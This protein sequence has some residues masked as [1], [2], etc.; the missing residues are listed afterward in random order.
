MNV[1]ARRMAQGLPLAD[2]A[3][4]QQRQVQ[5]VKTK[6][7]SLAAHTEA[8]YTQAHYLQA[9]THILA[10]LT[11]LSSYQIYSNHLSANTHAANMA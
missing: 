2:Y 10:S 11:W 8:A 4:M 7:P 1:Q 6:P 3:A 5:H 9:K